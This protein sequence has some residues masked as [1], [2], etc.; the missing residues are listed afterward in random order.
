MNFIDS[1]KEQDASYIIAEIGNNHQGSLDLALKMCEEAISCGVDAIKF[2]RRNN[3][4]LFTDEFYNSPYLNSN[5]FGDLYG[6]HR[7]K[8]ELSL[9]D[10]EKIKS[11]IESKKCDFLVTP[12]DFSSLEDLETIKCAFYKVA[13]ADIVHIPLI[14]KI[15]RTQ[16]P[17]IISTGFATYEDINRAVLI[18]DELKSNYSLLHCTASYPAEIADMNLNCI[19]EMIKRYP[20]AFK[21]GL[22]DHENG[23]D[24]ASIAYLL[25]ARIFEKHFTLNR[26]N[27]GTD[28]CF[29]LEPNG[30]KKLV[31]NIKRIPICL[32]T[33]SH[34]LL[35]A[36]EKPIFK[37][38]KSIVYKTN[39]VKD[40][41]LDLT[42]LEFRCPGN[43]LEPFYINEVIGKRL[44]TNVNRHQCFDF[45]HIHK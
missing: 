38:R 32:G 37:M 19:P 45:S 3:K 30:L 39:L 36:E 10:L 21:I 18:L 4:E 41:Q 20:K 15:A 31:R 27:K 24:C 33:S 26:A 40:A 22:S 42:N 35:K 5:S 17:M 29:S 6:E 9:Q 12:F 16:K 2:Q 28:N 13:S 25:G 11:Y 44:K 34:Q 7:D 1:L 23:I 14:K 8:L 43:G